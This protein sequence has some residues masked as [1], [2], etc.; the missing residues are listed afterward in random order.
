MTASCKEASIQLLIAYDD[1]GWV[2]EARRDTASD[3]THLS[4]VSRHCFGRYSRY[5]S[6]MRDVV[7]RLRSVVDATA[8]HGHGHAAVIGP[9]LIA[10]AQ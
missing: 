4:L 2:A 5:N 10:H 1:N 3:N 9:A 8:M 6:V 7:Q